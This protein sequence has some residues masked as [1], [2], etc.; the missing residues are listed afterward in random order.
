MFVALRPLDRADS[1][2][3]FEWRNSKAVAPFMYSDH[4]ITAEEHGRWFKSVLGAPTKRYWIIEVDGTPAGLANIVGIE[5]ANSRCEWAYYLASA[6]MRGRGVGAAVEY[7]VL[8]YVFEVLRLNK[9][10][11]EV[12]TDN[13]AVWAL[14]QSFGFKK[15]AELR[16]HIR[17]EGVFRD[18]IGLGLLRREWSAAR[19]RAEA[20]LVRK[21]TG[22]SLSER[23]GDLDIQT[24]AFPSPP[25][26]AP[27]HFERMAG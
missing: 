13:E 17:K 27:D 18:V 16:A 10:W 11:C 14:H 3:V 15:E 5:P 8:R 9:L 1:A 26:A 12:F 7:L 4:V 21:V 25:G 23:N 22:L 2:Q 19:E 20:R 24:I 6:D